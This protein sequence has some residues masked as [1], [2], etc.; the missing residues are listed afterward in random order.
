MVTL[1]WQTRQD[2]EWQLIWCLQNQQIVHHVG[3]LCISTMWLFNFF[4]AV[5]AKVATPT[6][7]EFDWHALLHHQDVL[8][9]LLIRPLSLHLPLIINIILLLLFPILLLFP[10]LHEV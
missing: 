9:I 10:L 5:A 7:G 1:I 3:S 4:V 6:K 8:N 2:G